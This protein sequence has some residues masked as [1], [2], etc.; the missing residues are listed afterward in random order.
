MKQITISAAAA[1]LLGAMLIC[2]LSPPARADQAIWFGNRNEDAASLIYGRPDSGYGKIAFTCQVGQ[3]ELMFTY[4]H[5]PIN[6]VDGVAVDA[7]LA[8][9]GV[10][11]SIPTI[12][13]RLE[14]DDVFLLEGQIRLDNALRKL[15]TSGGTLTIMVEDG[16]ESYPLDGAAQAAGHLLQACAPDA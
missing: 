12:G 5:E 4:E 2:S 11:V 8:A 13:A 10:E 16:A 6:A 7:V 1:A 15:L 14:I 9:G 3:D